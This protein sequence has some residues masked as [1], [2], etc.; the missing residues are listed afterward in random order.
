MS[1]MEGLAE[2]RKRAGKLFERGATQADVARELDVSRESA[3]RWY[4]VYQ[5]GGAKAL[6]TIGQRGRRSRLSDSEL[7]RVEKAL[8]KGALAHGSD[9]DEALIE[10]LEELRRYLRGAKVTLCWDGLASHRSRVMQTYLASSRRWLVVERLP[11]YA[12]DLNPVEALWG[13]LKGRELANLCVDAIEET[14]DVAH[15]GIERIGADAQLAFAF[16]AHT[17]LSL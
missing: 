7:A 14:E 6:A 16:L 1:D 17:G 5:R 10:F 3:R 2:R 11:A 13:N 8:L 4:E 12:P 15:A 9:N